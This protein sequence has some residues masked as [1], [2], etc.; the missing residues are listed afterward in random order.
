MQYGGFSISPTDTHL[1]PVSAL[2]PGTSLPKG[3]DGLA[4]T[5]AV[6]TSPRTSDQSPRSS[7]TSSTLQNGTAVTKSPQ[8]KQLLLASEKRRRRRESHNA[9]ERR[10]RDN[11]NEKISELA[12]LI[13][14]CMLEGGSADAPA[15][16]NMGVSGPIPTSQ[17]QQQT[18][19]ESTGDGI[20]LSMDS[21]TSPTSPL[22]INPIPGEDGVDLWG[23]LNGSSTEPNGIAKKESMDGLG[24]YPIGEDDQATP[25]PGA[26]MPNGTSPTT[27]TTTTTAGGSSAAGVKANKGMI[28]RKSVEYIRYLQQLVT[29]QGARNRELEAELLRHRSSSN[30]SDSNVSMGVGVGMGGAGMG[31]GMMWFGSSSSSSAPGTTNTASSNG[32]IDVDDDAGGTSPSAGSGSALTDPDEPPSSKGVKH[33]DDGET[34][35]G[36]EVGRGRKRVAKFA[37]GY[38]R[39]LQHN[40]LLISL[41]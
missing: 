22:S 23:D 15:P 17:Q 12:T 36:K 4:L 21:P 9:V 30:G 2:H 31:M 32:V 24:L 8:E 29:A 20:T 5:T 3:L 1:P 41:L 10:R 39:S 37:N 34:E 25:A 19:G 28:L 27:T 7:P 18:N 40:I 11:I 38:V 14:E 16:T 35:D 13:P 33:E 26:T 6:S